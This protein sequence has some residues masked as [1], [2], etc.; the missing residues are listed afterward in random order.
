MLEM[1]SV[2]SSHVNQV[3][4]DAETAELHVTYSNGKTAVYRGVDP[5]V[6][7]GVMSAASIGMAL[8]ETVRGRFDFGYRASGSVDRRGG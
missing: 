4:Y 5:K 8:H 6:A 2:F 7:G 3:G 1:R